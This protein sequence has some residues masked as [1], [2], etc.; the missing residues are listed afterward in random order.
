MSILLFMSVSII[1]FLVSTV[2]SLKPRR[3]CPPSV[4]LPYQAM[5]TLKVPK[6]KL[7]QLGHFFSCLG[8]SS[9]KVPF[10]RRIWSLHREKYV[11]LV[12]GSPLLG[13][14]YLYLSHTSHH[15]AV[16]SYIASRLSLDCLAVV[17]KLS[18]GRIFVPCS[19]QY[20]ISVQI[21]INP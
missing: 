12:V 16:V 20:L 14:E 1:S 8:G 21:V 4:D 10:Q 11:G 3:L 15:L 18:S 7:R 2:S 6:G 9:N 17:S 19:P 5:A 13:M